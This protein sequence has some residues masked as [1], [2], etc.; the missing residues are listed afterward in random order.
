MSPIDRL[1]NHRA[2]AYRATVT[3]DSFGGTVEGWVETEGT[4][5][6]LNSRPDQNWAGALQDHGPGEQQG[7]MRRWFL[8]REF[9]VEERDVLQVVEGAEAGLLLRVESVTKPT[10]VRPAIHH[11]EVNVEVWQGE[12]TAPVPVPPDT[13]EILEV[14]F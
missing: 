8:H 11:Y 1:W 10:R 6:G 3:R 4:P 14:E 7:A 5:A 13:P 12:L 2:V 9:D